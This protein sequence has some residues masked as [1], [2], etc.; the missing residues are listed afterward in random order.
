MPTRSTRIRM[1]G[2][3]KDHIDQEGPIQRNR[4]KQLLTLSLPKDD[5]ENINTMN[6]G[7]DLLHSIK[8]EE[9]RGC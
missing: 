2:Q 9:Q 7:R 4:P 6:K 1:D 5:V 8:L 3:R